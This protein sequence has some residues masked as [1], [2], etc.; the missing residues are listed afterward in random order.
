MQSN[1]LRDREDSR[2]L[3][4]ISDSRSEERSNVR[5]PGHPEN[6]RVC[7]GGENR[8]GLREPGTNAGTIDRLY[9]GGGQERGITR[10]VFLAAASSRPFNRLIRRYTRREIMASLCVFSIPVYIH[11]K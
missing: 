5:N 6:E 10:S 9:E 7:T 3:L 11:L 2:R 1:V 8:R 4:R